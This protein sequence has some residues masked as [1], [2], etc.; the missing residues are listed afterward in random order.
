VP[1]N[2]ILM[3]AGAS[4]LRTSALPLL[5]ARVV[6]DDHDASVAT[7]DFA[8]VT[9]LLDAG[10]DLH[11]ILSFRCRRAWRTH[12]VGEQAVTYSAI[13]LYR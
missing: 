10:V 11:V 4:R 8:F 13:Y 5:V 12:N 6:A 2:S 1:R 9:D 3:S 7:N